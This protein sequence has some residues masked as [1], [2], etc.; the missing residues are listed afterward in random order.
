MKI[1]NDKSL[2]LKEIIFY[3]FVANRVLSE[4]KVEDCVRLSVGTPGASVQ[5][6]PSRGPTSVLR[7]PSPSDTLSS[8]DMSLDA[9][10]SLTAYPLPHYLY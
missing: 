2:N 5:G 9:V 6:L 4:E 3:F 7:F 8:K 10:I 1:S